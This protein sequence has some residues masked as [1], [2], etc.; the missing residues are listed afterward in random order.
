[1]GVSR[2]PRSERL[3]EA[4]RFKRLLEREILPHVSLDQNSVLLRP[5]KVCDVGGSSLRERRAE[6]GEARERRADVEQD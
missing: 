5:K 1:L 2:A 6:I 3:L 4:R